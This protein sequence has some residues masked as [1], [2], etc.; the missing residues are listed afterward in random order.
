MMNFLLPLTDVV[1]FR[2]G[3]RG[4]GRAPRGT[5]SIRSEARPSARTPPRRISSGQAW[6]LSTDPRG[7]SALSDSRGPP[8]I[9]FD[10]SRWPP[11]IFMRSDIED[12]LEGHDADRHVDHVGARQQLEPMTD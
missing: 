2:F 6:L 5:A 10:A 8:G 12:E 3:A 11:S 7:P 4:P 9:A 1:L